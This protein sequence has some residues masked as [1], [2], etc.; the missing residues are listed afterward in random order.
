[1][2]ALLPPARP[3]EDE[4]AKPSQA[5]KLVQ[6]AARGAAR[7]PFSGPPACMAKLIMMRYK[8]RCQA[9]STPDLF[10]VLCT[11]APRP[12]IHC[13]LKLNQ[14][15]TQRRCTMT[16]AQRNAPH[17]FALPTPRQR[18]PV[19]WI[20]ILKQ[21]PVPRPTPR[22]SVPWPVP[23]PC[24]LHR[25][26]AYEKMTKRYEKS[27]VEKLLV[28]SQTYVLLTDFAVAYSC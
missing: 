21:P 24:F 15:N 6:L 1:L 13:S 2:T 18:L 9:L 17:Q 26:Q 8:V 10:S 14:V 28:S 19:A 5:V 27:L 23:C 3:K 7:V 20:H 16:L 4:L 11:H 25:Q 12:I 22:P